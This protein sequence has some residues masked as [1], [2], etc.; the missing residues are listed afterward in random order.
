MRERFAPASDGTTPCTT[1][2]EEERE[3]GRGEET[4][5]HKY[6]EYVFVLLSIHW[7]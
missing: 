6:T 1:H 3:G 2:R 4:S 7:V 5:L